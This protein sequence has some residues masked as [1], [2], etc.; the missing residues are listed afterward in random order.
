M[1][2]PSSQELE[3][4]EKGDTVQCAMCGK[5]KDRENFLQEI[6]QKTIRLR[7]I[8]KSLRNE[9][10]CFECIPIPVPKGYEIS[11]V[12]CKQPKNHSKFP[13]E[14][15]QKRISLTN[16]FGAQSITKN[17]RQKQICLA[18]IHDCKRSFWEGRERT[19]Q[20]NWVCTL[21]LSA[22]RIYL[23]FKA[24]SKWS[25]STIRTTTFQKKCFIRSRVC[26]T[27]LI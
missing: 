23:I 2:F 14:V 10:I 8:P 6:I 26:R 22:K 9:Q 13:Q 27:S 18:C 19:V 25:R 20:E 4:P 1:Q 12:V 7:K 21:Q 5:A 24:H 11:C 16:V 17:M 15:I 3:L